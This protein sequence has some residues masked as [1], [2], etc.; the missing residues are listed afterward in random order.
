MNT[1]Y[2]LR[3]SMS[4][5]DYGLLLKILSGFATEGSLV[6]RSGVGLEPGAHAFLEKLRPWITNQGLV[7]AW[8]G[9][10]LDEPTARLIRFRVDAASLELLLDSTDSLFDWLQ[11]SLPED[12]C[13]YRTDNSLVLG[14]T[15]HEQDAFLLL[16]PQEAALLTLR[17]PNLV[18]VDAGADTP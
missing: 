18:R 10:E 12:L 16:T 17:A 1:E 5:S 15:A 6:V 3:P 8:P 7:S 4:P 11:P 9:T 2:R 14:S 13:F